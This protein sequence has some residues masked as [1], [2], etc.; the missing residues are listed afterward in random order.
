MF[1]SNPSILNLPELLLS[2]F[3]PSFLCLIFLK[4]KKYKTKHQALL[5]LV[6]QG[7][8]PQENEFLAD[9]IS[10]HYIRNLMGLCDPP[11]VHDRI[12]SSLIFCRS[13]TRSHN[14]CEFIYAIA[15]WCPEN[16]FAVGIQ[17]LKTSLSRFP[18]DP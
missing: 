18:N 13:C 7:L 17:V 11:P 1:R 8:I 12:L 6:S 14:H 16:S 9:T 3:P 15:P 5:L 4:K 2:F 10:C